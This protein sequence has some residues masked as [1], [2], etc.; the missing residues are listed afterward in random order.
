MKLYLAILLI[1]AGLIGACSDKNLM[2]PEPLDYIEEGQNDLVFYTAKTTCD[3]WGVH[4]N[5]TL[6]NIA[7]EVV[8]PVI[9]RNGCYITL[10][11]FDQNGDS[12]ETYH[13][14]N[15]DDWKNIF[16]SYYVL[17]G[18]STMANLT[19]SQSDLPYYL[20][21]GHIEMQFQLKRN[22]WYASYPINIKIKWDFGGIIRR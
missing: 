14:F 19:V 4:L 10:S 22:K 5:I 13:Y 18:F 6:K 1:T 16:S 9:D 7:K 20:T 17:P 8:F 12:L 3:D 2:L 11:T 21:D 15:R